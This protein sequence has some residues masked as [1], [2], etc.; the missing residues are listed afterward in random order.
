MFPPCQKLRVGPRAEDNIDVEKSKT[1]YIGNVAAHL[2]LFF[3]LSY[4]LVCLQLW[5][6]WLW[7][8]FTKLNTTKT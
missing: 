7:I 2:F 3:L 6:F 8:K 1:A 4:L 5:I